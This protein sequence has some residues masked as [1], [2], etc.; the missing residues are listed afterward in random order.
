MLTSFS[1]LPKPVMAVSLLA[2]GAGIVTIFFALQSDNPAW[3]VAAGGLIAIGLIMALFKLVLMMRDR[4]K[5]SP[6]A[7]MISRGSGSGGRAGV[8]PAAKARMD[9]LRKK[10]EEGVTAFRSAGKDLYSLPWFLLVG[11]SGAGKTEALRHSNVGFPPG[12]QDCLQGTGGTLNMHWWF[13]NHAV[14]LDTAGRMF[15]EEAAEGQS[16]EWKEFLKL[17]KQARANCPVNGLLLV[18]SAESLLKDSSEKIEKTAGA[19]ARQLD[20]IQRTLEVRFPVTVLVTKCDKIVGFR[21]FFETV[22]DPT[23][24]HQMLG[25]SN[26]ASLDDAFRPENVESHLS[27]VRERLMKRRLGLIQNPVHSTDAQGRR[28][29]EVDQLFEFPD[30]MMRIAPRLRRYLELIFVAGEWSPKPLFLRG[31]YFTSS[32]RE[33]QALDVSLAQALGVD[34]ESLPGDTADDREKAYFLRDVFLGKVF[35][36]RGLVTRAANVGKHL[37]RQRAWIVGGSLAA[38]V[39]VGGMTLLS[40]FGYRTSLGPPSEFWASMRPAFERHVDEIGKEGRTPPLSLFSREG[41]KWVY[42]GEERPEGAL[43]LPSGM[44]SK[45]DVLVATGENTKE[46]QTPLVAWPVAKITNTTGRAFSDRQVMAHRALVES[47][48]LEPLLQAVRERIGKER[49]WSPAAVAALGQLVRLHTVAASAAPAVDSD[50]KNA[51]DA[52]GLVDVRV[53]S[54]YALGSD[55][56]T[57]ISGDL[58]RLQTAVKLAYP[59]NQILVAGATEIDGA[60]RRALFSGDIDWSWKVVE[61]ASTNLLNAVAAGNLGGQSDL[62]KVEEIC[63]ALDR[64]EQ[65]EGDPAAYAGALS[66][67]TAQGAGTD[68]AGTRSFARLDGYREFAQAYRARATEIAQAAG[69]IR[70]TMIVLGKNDAEGIGQALTASGESMV[71]EVARVLGQIRG[72]LPGELAPTTPD[73]LRS[74]AQAYSATQAGSRAAEAV[75]KVED[76]VT[77]TRARLNGFSHLLAANQAQAGTE[78]AGLRLYEAR[79][80]MHEL[81]GQAIERSETAGKSP[82]RAAVQFVARRAAATGEIETAV[83]GVRRLTVDLVWVPAVDRAVARLD[84]SGRITQGVLSV[85]RGRAD[86][87]VFEAALSDPCW[88]SVEAMGASV[89]QA[90]ADRID[91]RTLEESVELQPAVPLSAMIG[92]DGTRRTYDRRFLPEVAKDLFASWE[93]MEREL[94]AGTTGST[95]VGREDLAG[96]LRD[97]RTTGNAYLAEYLRYWEMQGTEAP[98][99]VARSWDEFRDGVKNMT[100]RMVA[101]P[102]GAA[103]RRSV[104]ALR[105]VP[106]SLAGRDAIKGATDAVDRAYAGLDDEFDRRMNDDLLNGWKRLG[107]SAAGSPATA[108][109]AAETLRRSIQMSRL[110]LD[111]FQAY[112]P[113]GQPGHVKYCNEL[114]LAGLGTIVQ[115]SQGPLGQAWATLTQTARAVPLARGSSDLVDL[116]PEQV[117]AVT[118]AAGM[119]GAQAPAPG[120]AAGGPRER[121]GERRVD[122]LIS[123]LMGDGYLR[124]ETAQRWFAGLRSAA[125][126]AGRDRI[127]AR[128]DYYPKET[129][130]PRAAPQATLVSNQYDYIAL[131]VDGERIANRNMT[132]LAPLIPRDAPAQPKGDVLLPARQGRAELRFYAADPGS[133]PDRFENADAVIAISGGAAGVWGP[134]RAAMIHADTRVLKATDGDGLDGAWLVPLTSTDGRYF[135]WATVRFIEPTPP[136]L[137]TWPEVSSWPGQ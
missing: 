61:A 96:R 99:P 69:E 11:P 49:E 104:E 88:T 110:R 67:L 135:I 7:A 58:S 51:D 108:A 21:E 75:K 35:K 73:S 2:G 103:R 30:N 41:D 33:G 16:S 52:Y 24:Q 46:I 79:A 66:W 115:A 98:M 63:N 82:E 118:D 20:T 38:A 128:V 57:R 1:G 28:I 121:I 9:D 131:F 127:L 37:A 53:L 72:Q 77:Q 40:I 85:A 42:L 19:I 78:G 43:G 105:L 44:R 119:M 130:K 123:Q 31:I 59:S 91:D 122:D 107:T 4:S 132:T 90:V 6:F 26:P 71:G 114:L 81:A 97:I 47:A 94:G 18:I 70:R 13:T 36:E 109:E 95:I 111:Y 22:S 125:D 89:R 17:L 87:S 133:R 54:N 25:W 86:A 64:F 65:V 55:E 39:V 74:M 83:A 80:R 134:M 56:T 15:M 101:G 27:G 106:E 14:V 34:V 10:F 100:G 68:A 32:M 23:L 60:S 12:L 117:K 62:G 8:D 5:S 126:F 129:A 136:A 3:K 137:Q 120:A 29:D 84:Q 112:V 48:A 102:L 50:P 116:S 113:Q 124:D 76:R 92:P 93:N 45:L